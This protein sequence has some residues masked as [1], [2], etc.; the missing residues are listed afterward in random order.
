M[1]VL[2]NDK[3]TIRFLLVAL[4]QMFM[5]D[6]AVKKKPQSVLALLSPWKQCICLCR[7]VLKRLICK[8]QFSS[9][10]IWSVLHL[11]SN[12]A[13]KIAGSDYA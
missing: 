1:L 5:P 2:M 4:A 8:T 13:E 7:E 3:A 6:L 9:Y 10:I 12:N 11:L